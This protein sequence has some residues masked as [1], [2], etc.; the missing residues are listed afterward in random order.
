MVDA[1]LVDAVNRGVIAGAVLD[2]F[3]IEPLPAEHPFWITKNI[4]VLPH[5]GGRHPQRDK[6]VAALFVE[7]ARRFA[8]GAPL[9]A[10]VDR[11]RGY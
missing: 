1:D 4:I 6:F 9:K 3:R 8:E 7:N 10:L 11:A 5:I 2:A